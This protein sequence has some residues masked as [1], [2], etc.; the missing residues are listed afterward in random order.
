MKQLFGQLTIGHWRL[1]KPSKVTSKDLEVNEEEDHELVPKAR[2][3]VGLGLVLETSL[4]LAIE[5]NPGPAPEA[6]LGI[7]LGMTVKAA[8]IV[9]YRAYA[10]SPRW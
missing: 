6:S 3:G 1:P 10:P 9:T 7:M 4:G 8:V 5:L 2:V